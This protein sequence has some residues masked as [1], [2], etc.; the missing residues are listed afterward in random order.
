MGRFVV[1]RKWG[2]LPL[3]ELESCLLWNGELMWRGNALRS[4]LDETVG[5]R[6]GLESEGP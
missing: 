5:V 6:K 3:P 4:F 1:S 2:Q